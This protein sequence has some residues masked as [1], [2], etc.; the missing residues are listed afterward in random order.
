MSNAL[1]LSRV[2]YVASLIPMPDWVLSELNSTVFNFFWS[3]KKD[4]V[5]RDVVV[6]PSESGGFSVVSTRFKV[7]S[8]LVQWI[9]RFASSPSGWVNLMAYWFRLYFDATPLEVFSAPSVFVPDLLPPFYAA[10]LKAWRTLQ[11]SGSSSG[12][13]V[14]S[15]TPRSIPVDVISCKLCYQL[16]LTLNPCQPHCV[17]KFRSAFPSLDWSST[18]KSLNFLPLDR[19]VI[20]LNWKVAH[21]VLYTAE[22][23]CSFGYDVPKACFCGFHIENPGHLFFSC[24]L[25]QSGVSW[26]QSLLVSASPLAPSIEVR[27]ML[28]GFSSDELRCVPKVFAYLLNVCKF[29]IWSQRNDFHFRTVAPSALRLLAS[30]K[31]RA[32]FYLPL[33]F[34]RFVSDRRRRFFNRQWGA[35]GVVGV[36]SG[37]RFLLRL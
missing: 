35:N 30:L 18:W 10:L 22:R 16:L 12:L 14:A 11:G 15:L 17:S 2:W 25:A 19:K 31:A 1:A 26:I 4:L 6:H 28:F 20:D 24:P 33:F 21:G 29:L 5:A 7:Q 32:S 36:V 3:G 37:D 13:V 27:H 8:L 9:K 34:K 23:L